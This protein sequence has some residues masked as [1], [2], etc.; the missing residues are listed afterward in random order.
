MLL[1]DQKMPELSGLERINVC[2]PLIQTFRS[3]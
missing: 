1:T 2:G 3:C